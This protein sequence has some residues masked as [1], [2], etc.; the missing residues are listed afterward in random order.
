MHLVNK[1]YF[2]LNEKNWTKL[3][4]TYNVRDWLSK[5]DVHITILY[6]IYHKPIPLFKEHVLVGNAL[7]C[8]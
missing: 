2:Y 5:M 6:Y 3:W 4:T 8:S 7:D 1:G